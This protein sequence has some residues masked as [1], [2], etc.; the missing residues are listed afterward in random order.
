MEDTYILEMSHI[1]KTFPGVRALGDGCLRLKKGEIHALIGENGAG[2]ST[3]MKILLG[4][5]PADSGE[6]IY[7]GE[8][9]AFSSPNQANHAGI[10]MIP[11]EVNMVETMDAAEN[12][13]LHREKIVCDRRVFINK[14][15]RLQA[16]QELFDR[17]HLNLDPKKLVAEYSSAQKQMLA[18]AKAVSQDS[19]VII[20]DEPTSS[21]SDSEVEMLFEVMRDLQSKGVSIVFISHKIEEIFTICQAITVLR[22]GMFISEHAT[23]DIT[24]EDLITQIAGRK[25]EDMYPPKRQKFGEVV[26]EAK[27]FSAHG[28]Y[29]NI[30]LSVRE[31]EILGLYGLVGAGRSE[32]MR[33]IY[34]V[35][36][37]DSG[38][39]LIENKKARIRHPKNSIKRGVSMVTEDRLMTGIISILSVRENMSLAN[40]PSYCNKLKFVQESRE[41]REV[42]EMIERMNVKL[43]TPEQPIGSLSGGNQ[44]KAILGK[45]LLTKPKVLILDEPTRGIDVGAKYEIYSLIANLAAE[46][47]AVILISS[48]L[49]E[50][51][52][53]A[54]RVITFCEGRITAEFSDNEIE[55]ERIVHAAF[56]FQDAEELS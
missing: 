55:Q 4:D 1:V 51:M 15:K 11:Q 53:M 29:N 34:G 35:D 44:Q 54:D 47:M 36:R 25:I 12:V 46:G 32:V 52:G 20:M 43:S 31:G 56:G 24:R 8:K 9:V 17:M 7:K 41:E 21:L 3:L 18:I 2:K 19:E 49:P 30:S 27:N 26:F 48:E 37:H 14:K 50:M 39:V 40:L 22:D 38:E 42:D 13:W 28:V 5:Y 10:C 45:W 33:A 16:T 6:I 23:G